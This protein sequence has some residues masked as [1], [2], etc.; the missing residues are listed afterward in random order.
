M[1]LETEFFGSILE[2]QKW[3]YDNHLEPIHDNTLH[4]ESYLCID[5]VVVA[6][7]MSCN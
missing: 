4:F 5:L 7:S 6:G 1:Q 3:F 2:M